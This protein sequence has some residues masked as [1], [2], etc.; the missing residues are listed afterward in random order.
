M[1]DESNRP[2]LITGLVAQIVSDQEVILNRGSDHG[3]QRGDIFAIL[4][5]KT[6]AISDPVTH[7]ELGGI[8]R[9]KITVKASSVAPKV[10]L[11]RTYRT[12]RVNIGGSGS[13]FGGIFGREPAQYVDQVETFELRPE[14]P[15][16]ISRDKSV[17]SVGDPF[18]GIRQQ[19]ADD[20]GL[21]TDAAD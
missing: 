20:S 14:D 13:S 7:E 4:D 16:P 1:S 8:R 10:T 5:P 18:E 12:R 9:V 3:V 6:G 15:R 21:L 19:R 11:A 17:V 2:D